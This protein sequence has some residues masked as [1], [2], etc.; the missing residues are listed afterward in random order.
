M[1]RQSGGFLVAVFGGLLGAVGGSLFG[2]AIARATAVGDLSDLGSA[3]LWVFG[4]AIVGTA[5]GSGIAL[6]VAGRPGALRTAFWTLPAMFLMFFVFVGLIRLLDDAT[7]ML[8]LLT[9][10]AMIL[11]LLAARWAALRVG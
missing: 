1:E 3:L 11:M 4:M 2:G 9:G 8:W 5:F 7:V 10:I 6:A